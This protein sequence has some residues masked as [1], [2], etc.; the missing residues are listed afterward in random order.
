[1]NPEDAW[2]AL[3]SAL[4]HIAPLCKGQALFTADRLSDDERALCEST[5]TRCALFDLCDAYA[6]AAKVDAGYWAGVER[7]PKRRITQSRRSQP[8]TTAPDGIRQPSPK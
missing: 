6:T 4:E 1:M 5:C 2:D 8:S 3:N 7:S